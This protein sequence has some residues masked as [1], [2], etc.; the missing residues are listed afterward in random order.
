MPS[1]HCVADISPSM[2]SKI[3]NAGATNLWKESGPQDT[4]ELLTSV[5][6][7]C[8]MLNL[9]DGMRSDVLAFWCLS[10]FKCS[11]D[12]FFKKSELL[13]KKAECTNTELRPSL[14]DGSPALLKPPYILPTTA[15][16]P[17]PDRLP[18]CAILSLACCLHWLNGI[19]STMQCTCNSSYV[20]WNKG[21]RVV[22]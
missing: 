3:L 1:C 17:W 2:L 9:T 18:S 4:S 8:K 10:W 13:K 22:E 14:W 12:S 16:A 19:C 5:N 7:Q 21:A 20:S 11:I 6:V 15:A